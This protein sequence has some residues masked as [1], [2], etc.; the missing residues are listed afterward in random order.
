ME[1][2]I[3]PPPQAP[4][5]KASPQVI[6]FYVLLIGLIPAG[7]LFGER[8]SE[9]SLTG[10]IYFPLALLAV[11]AYLGQ[12]TT[13]AKFLAG[14]WLFII[15]GV[16]SLVA[17][18][19]G[20]LVVV[21]MDTLLSGNLE[22]DPALAG[23]ILGLLSITLMG[24]IVACLGFIPPLRRGLSRFLPIDPNS[25]VHTIA[26]VAIVGITLIILAPLII[27]GEP[28][29]L[30]DSFM[31]GMA[32]QG[33]EEGISETDG[34]L[35]TIYTLIWSVPLAFMAV[36][37]GIQRNFRQTLERVGLVRPSLTQVGVGLAAALGLV[38]AVSALEI[39]INTVWGG[40]GWPRT[41]GEAFGELIAFAFNPLGAIVIGVSAGLGEELA[42]RGVLQPRLGILLSNLFFA[43]LH[44]MQYNWD[45]LLVVFLVGAAFGIL[46]TR[47]NTSVAA[48]AHGFYNFTLIMMATYGIS[49]F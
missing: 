41:D 45:S 31:Q 23:T 7:F 37:Y 2:P 40:M 21:E 19:T 46:R 15:F 1:E 26:L 13:P 34:L 36:G 18:G 47:T 9:F 20:A 25:F 10:L 39:G 27:T 48:I 12:I 17:L 11:L 22:P 32:E 3:F 33:G 5:P 8:A 44:A 29:L 4:R 24:V 38:V 49:I 6:L 14:G 28:P 42:V 30:S 43:S 35:S 16:A